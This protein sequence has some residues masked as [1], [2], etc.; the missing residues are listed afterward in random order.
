VQ[1]RKSASRNRDAT[2]ARPEDAE[3]P[4]SGRERDR[5]HASKE[6]ARWRP[7]E[8]PKG[9]SAQASDSERWGILPEKLRQGLEAVSQSAFMARYREAL[10]AYY[11]RL[12]D[13]ESS[14]SS[15]SPR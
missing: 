14:T 5:I 4:R 6:T 11:K 12:A 1:Q 8:A 10:E 7:P 13:A 9:G 2:D 3:E 15:S